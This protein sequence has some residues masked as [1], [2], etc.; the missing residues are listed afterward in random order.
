MQ[1]SRLTGVKGLR[2]AI[3]ASL[4]LTL[5]QDKYSASA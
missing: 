4:G 2:N 3:D 5:K 1:Q